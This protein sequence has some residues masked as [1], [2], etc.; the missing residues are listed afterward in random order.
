L[1]RY[2]FLGQGGKL[3]VVK[4][5]SSRVFQALMTSWLIKELV[6]VPDLDD[7]VREEAVSQYWDIAAAFILEP[8]Q[9]LS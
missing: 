3:L 1:Q 5:L 4:L 9:R 2:S 8:R 7:A 6:S